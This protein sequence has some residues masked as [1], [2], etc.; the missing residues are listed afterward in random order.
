MQDGK[1]AREVVVSE[2]LQIVHPTILITVIDDQVERGK[3]VDNKIRPNIM[4]GNRGET[5]IFAALATFVGQGCQERYKDVDNPDCVDHL[6]QPLRVV[7]EDAFH[8]D[9]VFLVKILAARGER[10]KY[11]FNHKGRH[12]DELPD[13]IESTIARVFDH[14][15]AVAPVSLVFLI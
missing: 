8:A 11:N 3:Y 5:V 1:S 13:L 6:L 15:V 9:N 12:E 7:T 2:E 4:F 10:D 14:H